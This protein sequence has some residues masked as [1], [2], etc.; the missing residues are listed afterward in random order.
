MYYEAQVRAVQ[1]TAETDLVIKDA[2]EPIFENVTRNIKKGVA[3]LRPA[4]RE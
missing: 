1:I 4:M 2:G 3:P